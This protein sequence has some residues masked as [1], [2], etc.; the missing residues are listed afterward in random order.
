MSPTELSIAT[1]FHAS[2]GILLPEGGGNVIDCEGMKGGG[3][4][5]GK[6]SGAKDTQ[7]VEAY[8]I[9]IMSHIL[10]RPFWVLPRSY[11]RMYLLTY[12]QQ[13]FKSEEMQEQDNAAGAET[14][15]LNK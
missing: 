14:K 9:L 7:N 11:V 6:E 4:T 12:I 1:T 8:L 3:L 2:R 10:Q 5:M 15:D 13:P